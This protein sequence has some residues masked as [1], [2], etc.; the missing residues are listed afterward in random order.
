MLVEREWTSACP[1]K[2]ETEANKVSGVGDGS[3]SS[4]SIHPS[5][6]LLA[7]T[8]DHT[9]IWLP[10]N[11]LLWQ[12]SSGKIWTKLVVWICTLSPPPPALLQSSILVLV[13]IRR[14][15]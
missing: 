13:Y 11:P 2:C 3:F 4:Y 8:G 14:M 9:P 12:D 6:P 15:I 1:K 7:R 10:F 5:W